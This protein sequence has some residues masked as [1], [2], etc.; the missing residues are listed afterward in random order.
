MISMYVYTCSTFHELWKQICDYTIA[1]DLLK[2]SV[3]V[4]VCQRF[5]L[6]TFWPV[7]VLVCWRFGLPTFWFVDISVCPH[8]GWSTF[9]F[10]DISVC[11][12]FGLSTFWSVDDLVCR[13]FGL[14]MFWLSTFR[15]VDVL[16][17]YLSNYVST[18]FPWRLQ[19]FCLVARFGT[20]TPQ[21]NRYVMVV[22]KTL[23]F[24]K[25]N[26][27]QWSP[28]QFH[29]YKGDLYIFILYSICVI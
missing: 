12:S 17:S 8:F 3:D 14:S 19:H 25:K 23:L 26:S 5:G 21:C 20:H 22:Y 27:L 2:C 10:V 4:S 1:Y 7:D 6:L 9:R 28:K 16:T 24:L 11:R 15:F 29:Y 18:M 13:Q